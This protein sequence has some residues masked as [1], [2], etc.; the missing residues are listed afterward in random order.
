MPIA[1]AN[2]VATI[3]SLPIARHGPKFN[4]GGIPKDSHTFL[5]YGPAYLA[6]SG[7]INPQFSIPPEEHPAVKTIISLDINSLTKSTLKTSCPPAVKFEHP[8]TPAT[9]FISPA[10]NKSISGF[11][12]PPKKSFN[13]PS[14]IPVSALSNP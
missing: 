10:T 5:S 8:T 4:T 1:S 3:S 2:S 6:A 14:L 12:F 9:P 11:Q 7:F 13:E